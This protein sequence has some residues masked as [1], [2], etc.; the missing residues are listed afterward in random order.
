V[1]LVQRARAALERLPGG[2][3]RLGLLCLFIVLVGMIR[4]RISQ[5]AAVWLLVGAG[6]LVAGAATAFYLATRRVAAHLPLMAGSFRIVD[7]ILEVI[8]RTGL[9]LLALVF[10]LFW[11][12]VYLG[13]WRFQSEVAFEGLGDTGDPRFSDFFY[14]AV[15]TAFTAPPEG[16]AALSRGARSATMIEVVTGIALITTYFSSLFEHRR[17]E[18]RREAAAGE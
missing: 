4:P 10:F 6:V 18:R 8:R 3:V 2:V 12:F 17:Q 9:P 14:Y 1:R 15:M 7:A 11:T 13:I 16:I 5:E